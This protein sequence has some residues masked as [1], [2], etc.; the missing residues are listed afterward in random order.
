VWILTLPRSGFVQQG[1]VVAA[2]NAALLGRLRWRSSAP[3]HGV[4]LQAYLKIYHY[5][6]AI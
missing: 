6:K 3:K 4:R 5:V 2:Q 1:V